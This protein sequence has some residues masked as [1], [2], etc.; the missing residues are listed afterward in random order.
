[1][2]LKRNEADRYSRVLRSW[3]GATAVLIAGGA[4]V[5]PEQVRQVEIAHKLEKVKCVVI[6][7]AYLLAPW[8]DVLYAADSRWWA[9]HEKG[10]DKPALKLTA[11]EVRQRFEAFRGERCSIQY[12]GAGI[13]D[14]RVHLVKNMTFPLPNHSLGLSLDPERLVT[15]RNSGFQALNLIT[16]TGAKKVLLLGIDGRLGVNDASHFHGGHPSP[17]P[18]SMFFE[19]MRKTFSAAETPLKEAGVEVLNCSPGTAIDSFPKIALQEAIA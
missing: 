12:S 8:A 2:I 15:G 13:T 5:T 10:L 18:W 19:Q 4:S 9:W 11:D 7:D 3:E 6:N 1:M 14:E 16:L 17:T